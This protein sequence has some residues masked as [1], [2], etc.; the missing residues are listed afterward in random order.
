MDADVLIVGG[1]PSGLFAAAELARH[2]LDCRLVERQPT[3][4]RQARAT[5]LQTASLELLE[6]AGVLAPFLEQGIPLRELWLLNQD[7]EPL[8]TVRFDRVEAPWPFQLSLPQWQTEALLE[9]HLQQLGGR[10]E[11]GTEVCSIHDTGQRLQVELS[12][13][14]GSRESLA[15]RWLIGASGAHSLVRQSMQEE[16]EGETYAHQHLAVEA[17]LRH[18]P[19]PEKVSALLVSPEGNVLFA[20]LPQGRRLLFIELPEAAAAAA[21]PTVA[22]MAGVPEP[23]RSPSAEAVEALLRQR[24]GRDLGLEDLSWIAPFRMHRRIAPRLGDGRRFLIGDSAHLCS[25]LGGEGMNAGLM[26]AADLAWKL[27]LVAR[28]RA[29]PELLQTYAQERG[30]ADRHVLEVS[31]RLHRGVESLRSLCDATGSLRLPPGGLPEDPQLD[32]SRA[33]LDLSYAGSPL[34]GE[35]LGAG[36]DRPGGPAPGERWPDRCH[37]IATAAAATGH[38][39]L[40]FGSPPP[41]LDGLLRRWSPLLALVDGRASGLDPRRAGLPADG[42]VSGLV[43]VRP[44]GILGWRSLPAD[45]AGL[46]ALEAHLARWFTSAGSAG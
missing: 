46:A 28:G 32:R 37:P 42:A 20:A 15:L 41:G 34:V 5:A 27:A 7:L 10:L 43:L 9:R 36:I 12:H 22:S 39:L 23:A 3:P 45:Q 13:A 2:G 14:D 25:P 11:R 1:G 21:T 31:D 26:D 6:R 24:C 44:D 40:L 4:H 18:A 33:M 38:L 8:T 29:R 16:L 17:R 35:H 30:L 19:A